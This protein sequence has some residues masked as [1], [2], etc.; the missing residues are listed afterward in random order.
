MDH[1]RTRP[2]RDEGADRQCRQRRQ[3]DVD[4]IGHDFSARGYSHPA[5]TAEGQGAVGRR[6]DRPGRAACRRLRHMGRADHK[7]ILSGRIGDADSRA[8]AT[9]AQANEGPQGL[10]VD[11]RPDRKDLASPHAPTQPS[12][13]AGGTDGVFP[14]T[15][16]AVAGAKL[17]G[18]AQPPSRRLQETLS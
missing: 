5:D 10:V 13:Q 4:R 12:A 17:V 3:V 6:I 15:D 7:W 8:R 14:N 11:V 18:I 16:R 2:A 1:G 9:R